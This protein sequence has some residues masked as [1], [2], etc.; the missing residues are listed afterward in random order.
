MGGEAVDGLDDHKACALK[1]KEGVHP[2][3]LKVVHRA[4]GF[5]GLWMPWK[6][7]VDLA[8]VW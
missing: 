6:R 2:S 5:E 1:W 7:M 8:N 3:V 4:Q